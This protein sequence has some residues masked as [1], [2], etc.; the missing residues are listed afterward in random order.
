MFLPGVENWFLQ[1][2]FICLFWDEYFQ[3]KK[4]NRLATGEM[5]RDVF[6]RRTQREIS[7]SRKTIFKTPPTN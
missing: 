5:F 7:F 3:T 2:D 1:Q 6:R 4:F